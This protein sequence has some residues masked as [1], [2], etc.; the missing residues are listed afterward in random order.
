MKAVIERCGGI[1]VAKKILNV[2]ALTG[3]ADQE[4]EAELGKYGSFNADLDR[5]REWLVSKGCT[6]V[7]MESTGSYWKPVYAALEGSGIQVLLANGED[8]KARRG[9]KT[10][11]NDCQFLAH[12]LRHGMIRPS[13]IPPQAIRDLRDLTRR[14][15]QLIGAATS[16]RNRVQ[17]ILEE[18]N[19]KLGS[20]LSDI[21]GVSGQ[22][23]LE[24]LLEGEADLAA[25]ANLARKK[26]RLKI[27]EIRQ[28][29]EGHRLRD[30]HRL[31]IRM[32]LDHLEFLE[33]QLGAIDREVLELTE[34][35]GCRKAFDRCR[36]PGRA[37]DLGCR[38]AGG[39][40]SGHERLPDRRATELLDRGLPRKPDQRGQE[41]EF[42]HLQREQMG[43]HG[44]GGMRLG[45]RSEEGLPSAGALPETRRQ[46]PESRPECRRAR[47]GKN[48][49]PHAFHRTALHGTE[50]AH[51]R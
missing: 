41:P 12:L 3:G 28:S 11:W 33:N 17:K 44:S 49:P 4:P 21:F 45:R 2:C 25:I 24:K 35:E 19:I 6:H 38:A 8:V 51:C 15:R 47:P 29:L 5:L 36:H 31:M 34:R 32:S 27:P 1:D 30:H 9:H 23:M 26:A 20:V 18:A 48:H 14:R 46:G 37:G 43:A 10:D 7:V 42:G 50:P 16:E 22:L 13:F 40:R 39:N